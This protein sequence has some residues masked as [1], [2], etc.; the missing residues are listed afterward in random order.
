[1]MSRHRMKLG[2]PLGLLMVAVSVLFVCV[3]AAQAAAPPVKQ[4]IVS[5]FG[6]KV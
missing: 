1:M 4:D 2:L 5:H 3:G 6:A